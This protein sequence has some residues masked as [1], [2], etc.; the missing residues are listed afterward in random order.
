VLFFHF[1]RS[2]LDFSEV[3]S[4]EVECN[5]GCQLTNSCMHNRA[6]LNEPPGDRPSQR[7]TSKRLNL[8]LLHLSLL[9][10]GETEIEINAAPP[11]RSGAFYSITSDQ[12]RGG[13]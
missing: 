12:R 6:W 5:D 1:V 7:M 10:L 4:D 11:A 8:S 2:N 13:F 3:G 9:R